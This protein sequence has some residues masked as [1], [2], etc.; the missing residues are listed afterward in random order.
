MEST[1]TTGLQELRSNETPAASDQD[2][3]LTRTPE[4]VD[5]TP[6]SVNQYYGASSLTRDASDASSKAVLPSTQSTIA[7]KEDSFR[8]LG[9]QFQ[10]EA[11]MWENRKHVMNDFFGEE[12]RKTGHAR[13]S[14]IERPVEVDK[15][16]RLREHEQLAKQ[17]KIF[18][19]RARRL[20]TVEVTPD[21]LDP[22]IKFWRE[23]LSEWP[24]ESERAYMGLIPWNLWYREARGH[25]PGE[26]ANSLEGPL[27]KVAGLVSLND[28]AHL[29]EKPTST[30]AVENLKSI[31]T[32]EFGSSGP[33]IGIEDLVAR[34]H[35]QNEKSYHVAQPEMS[36]KCSDQPVADTA[37]A[38]DSILGQSLATIQCPLNLS[39]LDVETLSAAPKS[40]S[41]DR[42]RNNPFRRRL[43]QLLEDLALEEE[44]SSESASSTTDS[45]DTSSDNDHSASYS[46][47]NSHN[48]APNSD[49]PGSSNGSRSN[50]QHASG[51]TS[52]TPCNQSIDSSR[53]GHA[54]R[55]T[56]GY[57][58]NECVRTSTRQTQ[59]D[60][61][62]GK[63]IPCP[64]KLELDC[65]GADNNMSSLL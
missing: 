45:D 35:H 40:E 53:T 15:R 47:Y 56:Q 32:P 2:L 60:Q 43:Q 20:D 17:L 8:F 62:N 4:D 7:P 52:Q 50:G 13:D 30:D 33:S 41:Q 57:G 38:C 10:D 46:G 37:L 39:Q 63:V 16:R 54:P 5:R 28:E 29:F 21:R 49:S 12:R 55:V 27:Y 61:K 44:S 48:G 58:D 36:E 11:T 3:P 6:A 42:V 24:E 22:E 9:T 34:V 31:I 23:L 65:A 14:R 26:S 59:N 1:T 64:L 19:A 51:S 25:N 18:A